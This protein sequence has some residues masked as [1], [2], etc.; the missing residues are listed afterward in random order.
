MKVKFKGILLKGVAVGEFFDS[1]ISFVSE[2][3]YDKWLEGIGIKAAA[4]K[5]DFMVIDS[6][7]SVE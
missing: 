2:K 7:I 3:E 4:G 6:I 1:S 5:S